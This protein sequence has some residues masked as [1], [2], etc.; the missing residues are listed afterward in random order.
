MQLQVPAIYRLSITV[1][2]VYSCMVFAYEASCRKWQ[3]SGLPCGHVCAVC[4]EEKLTNCNKWAET[5]FTKTALKG[6]YHEM[7]Y[8]LEIESEWHDPGNLQK[9]KPPLMD[10]RQAGRPKNKDR[11]PS[12]NEEPKVRKCGRCGTVG[13]TR[14]SCMEP[15][16]RKQVT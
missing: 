5:W 2:V 8:P 14:A 12:K 4:R 3:L 10:K 13:H 16:P 7:V 15:V 1:N 6:T 9:V 11:F